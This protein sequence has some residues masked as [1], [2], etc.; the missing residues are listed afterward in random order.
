MPGMEKN[1]HLGQL[2]TFRIGGTPVRFVHPRNEASLLAALAEC[3]RAS[4]PW[5]VL[6]GGSK[7]LVD[8]GRLPYAVVRVHAPGFDGIERTGRASVRVG[9]GVPTGRLLTFCRDAGLGGLEFMV[10]LPG[11]V[12][13]AV[14][15]NAGAW[16]KE[17]CALVSRLRVVTPDEEVATIP[18]ARIEYSYRQ[19][20][21]KGAVITEAEFDLSPRDSRLIALQ[22]A[23]YARARSE[24][25]PMSERSAG[26]VF[27]NPPGVSAG[28]LLDECGLKGLMVGDAQISVRHANFIIN[29][30]KAASA[31][32]LRLIEVM[33]AAVRHAFGIELELEVRHWPAT[34]A[35]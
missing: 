8:E 35:A 15:G 19:T 23:E 31:D 28:K 2:T 12:G 4:L 11:T 32:V 6:G 13:G 20:E 17:I 25:H 21:L 18:R 3:R 26:C 1:I 16:G 10:A 29:R 24:R 30:G 9:A 22:M 33:R 27:R 7:L 14:A 34:N 5:R